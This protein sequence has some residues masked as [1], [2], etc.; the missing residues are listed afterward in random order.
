MLSAM[1]LTQVCTP[2]PPPGGFNGKDL[3]KQ[4]WRQV[5]HLAD[6]FWSKWKQEYLGTLQSR[7]RWQN[8]RLNLK[9]GDPVLLKDGQVS[10]NKWPMGLIDKTFHDRDGKVRKVEVKIIKNGAAKTYE[11]PVSETVLLMSSED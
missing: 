2:L 9:V 4:Q 1:L 7:S 8:D 5:Q 11:R 10:R 3:H 6:M